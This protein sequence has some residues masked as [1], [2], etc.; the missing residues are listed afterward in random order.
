VRDGLET[1]MTFMEDA[2][3]PKFWDFGAIDTGYPAGNENWADPSGRITIQVWCGTPINC[4]NGNE[5][6]SFHPGGA[7][8]AMAGGAVVYITQNIKKFTFQALFTV[9][10]GDIPDPSWYP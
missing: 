2:G 9:A 10:N 6:F 7:N 3:R 8:F 5:I 4:N 1:T